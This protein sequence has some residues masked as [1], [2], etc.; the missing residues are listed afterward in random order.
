MTDTIPPP[1]D[2]YVVQQNTMAAQNPDGLIAP[3]NIDLS[4][5]PIAKNAD[6]S[7]STVRSISVDGD[8]GSYLIP[9]VVNGAVVPNDQAIKHFQKTGE[10]LGKFKTWQQADKYAETLHNEQAKDYDAQAGQSSIPPPPPGYSVQAAD[11]SSP[12]AVSPP[13]Q[14]PSVLDQLG[15]A[16]ALTGRGLAHGATSLLGVVND[17]IVAG[18]NAAESGLGVDPKY[19]LGNTS[20][21]TDMALNAAGVPQVTPQNGAENLASGL[22]Q[23][24]GG[25]ASGIGL[26][27]ALAGAANPVVANIGST[28]AANPGV[29]T[30]AAASG[31]AGQDIAKESG[32]SPAIQAA[33]GVAAGLTPTALGSAGSA[34]ARYL[35]GSIPVSRQ[36]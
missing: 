17:P 10:N 29:Q 36:A 23:G 30:A 4:K 20:Q 8:D 5:R 15:R 35:A 18:V 16:A 27:S 19:R 12:V 6:G 32:A 2:G 22:A 3:G 25:V 34:T 31:T 7:Y 1:P 9:T 14:D 28:L 33:A 11:S 24:L 26:G 13:T 21:A